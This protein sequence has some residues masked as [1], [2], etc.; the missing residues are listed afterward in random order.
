MNRFQ[1]ANLV[2]KTPK[3][4]TTD[5]RKTDFGEGFNP[6]DVLDLI[7]GACHE[8]TI[9]RCLMQNTITFSR[10]AEPTPE[11]VRTYVTRERSG[12]FRKGEDGLFYA[13]PKAVAAA[14]EQPWVEGVEALTDGRAKAFADAMEGVEFTEVARPCTATAT[15]YSGVCPRCGCVTQRN[16]PGPTQCAYGCGSNLITS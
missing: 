7:V 12:E 2:R 10:R 15:V 9:S 13:L 14:V 8:F 5:I 1:I 16:Q 11:G 4:G 6:T 3:G